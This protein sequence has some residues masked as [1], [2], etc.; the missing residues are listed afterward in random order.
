VHLPCEIEAIEAGLCGAMP[1]S[2]RIEN[3]ES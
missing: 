3:S 1:E 2:G